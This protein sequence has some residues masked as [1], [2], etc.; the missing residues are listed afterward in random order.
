MEDPA[1][2]VNGLKLDLGVRANGKRVDDVKLPK[3]ADSVQDFLKKNR[4]ALE[5][6][7]VSANL[8]NWIDLV[9]G[10]KQNKIEFDNVYHP[11]SYEGFINFSQVTDPNER[12]AYETHIREF[13]QT[14]RMLFGA[15]HPK[16]GVSVSQLKPLSPLPKIEQLHVEESKEEPLKQ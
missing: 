8:H 13:G 10:C 3:W 4:E 2:L 9:F 12:R 16:R 6:P 15:L 14:P 7:Y 5:S 11:Y 1:F